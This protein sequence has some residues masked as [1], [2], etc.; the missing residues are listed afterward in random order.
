MFS[1]SF[2]VGTTYLRVLAET[3]MSVSGN[4]IDCENFNG[5]LKSVFNSSEVNLNKV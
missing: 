4:V 1:T 3:G 5:Y 2:N